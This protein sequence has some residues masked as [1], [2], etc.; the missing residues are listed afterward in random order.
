MKLIGIYKITSPTDKIYIGQSGDVY[1]RWSSY[2]K[3]NCVDQPKLYRSL[4][5]YGIDSHIFEIIE[6]CIIEQLDEKEIYWGLYYNSL[7]EG[8]NCRLGNGRGICSEETKT[9]IGNKQ[10]GIS[11][12]KGR[13]S[14]N[15]GNLYVMSEDT[16]NKMKKP[17]SYSNKRFKS[18]IQYDLENN[19]IKKWDSIKEAAMYIGTD[20]GTLCQCL[21]G[22]IPTVKKYIWKY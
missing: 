8:L 13:K 12:N 19:F 7:N 16:K 10:R 6:E 15:K 5:K 22:K 18:I 17:K 2:F 1:K 9:K 4:I 11:K 20:S 21:K 14:P 3:L